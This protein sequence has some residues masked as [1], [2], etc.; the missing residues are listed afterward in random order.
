M[1]SGLAISEKNKRCLNSGPNPLSQEARD[2]VTKKRDQPAN[3]I[4]GKK[5]SK[6]SD[7]IVSSRDEQIENRGI[8]EQFF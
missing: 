1:I 8:E 5:H 4:R 7:V 2:D 6:W 3:Q